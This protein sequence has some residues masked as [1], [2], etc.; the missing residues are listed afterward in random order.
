MTAGR[1]PT[2]KEMMDYFRAY[3]PN[4]VL[5]IETPFSLELYKIARRHRCK[6]VGIPMHET[7]SA[8]RLTPDLFI[9]TCREAWEKAA[10]NKKLLFLPIGL[11]LFPFRER[12]GHTFVSSIGYGGVN[13]RRQIGKIVK[14]FKDLRDSSARLIIN[15]Q[16]PLPKGVRINDSRVTLNLQ[17][18]PEP[19]DVYAEGDISILPIAYGG[20]ERPILESMASG[21][22]TLTMDADPMNL[23]QHDSD[24][25]LKPFRKYEITDQW[26]R[27]TVY[28]EVSARALREKM[29]WLLT[30][31]TPK[32]SRQARTQAEAQSWESKDTDYVGIWRDA[33]E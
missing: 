29:Q 21:M 3:R 28:N 14:A 5:F 25:L 1:P 4:V 16:A 15:S 17:T 27:H 31:D 32:Y 6:V 24:F 11:E 23:F 9:C 33:L 7:F 12:T 10:G 18:Y 22:P 26:V 30:I 8:A 13:D 19:K 2:R 20:Y